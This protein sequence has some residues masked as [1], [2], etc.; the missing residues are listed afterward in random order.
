MKPAFLKDVSTTALRQAARTFRPVISRQKRGIRVAIFF[1]FV[2]TGLKL[3]QPWPLKFVLDR[4]IR[5]GTPG[6]WGLSP[7]MTVGAAAVIT[8][9]LALLQGGLSL[10]LTKRAAEVGRDLAVGIRR[11]VFEH[12]HR[13]ELPFHTSGRTGE[14]LM[15]LTGDVD[16]VRDGLFTQWLRALGAV[17]TFV[18]MVGIMFWLD[19]LLAAVAFI[20]LPVVLIVLPRASRRLRQAT[21][22]QRKRQGSAAAMAAES[23]R[24]IRV[25]KAYTAEDRTTEDFSK[26]SRAGETAGVRAARISAEMERNTDILTGVGLALVLLFGAQ[27]VVSHAITIG[28]LVVFLAYARS[29]YR[30]IG[31]VSDTAV[32]MG[33][34]SAAAERMLQVLQ[35][36]PEDPSE[37]RSAPQFSGEVAFDRVSYAY[38]EGAQALRDVS[39][40][41]PPGSLAMLVGPNG[42]GKS[43]IL[44]I[45]LRLIRPDEG[46][47][48]IDGDPIAEFKVNSYRS[49]FA[50]VPQAIQLFSG[51]L[52]ENIQ[53]GRLDASDEEI[54]EAA[55][56]ALLDDVVDRLPGG[57]EAAL[58]EGGETLSGGEARRLM[59]A[60]AAIRDARVLILDEPLTGLDPDATGT[61]AAAL[62]QI[63]AGRTTI[64][65]SHEAVSEFSPDV[66][67]HLNAGRV[68]DVTHPHVDEAVPV[69]PREDIAAR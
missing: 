36:T 20:P 6:P 44:S 51:T 5:Q 9:V 61:V 27:R 31:N 23:L 53:Y 65:V 18:I 26:E 63:A 62:R 25:V 3:L 64:V 41:L 50:Y 67:V 54:E 2:T 55:R 29:F 59:L 39:F 16:I 38:P 68:V 43:T 12:L 17:M 45:L 48:R 19:P 33:R 32:R 69:S 47:V 13:L 40:T 58:G 52:K 42:S 66:L 46:E 22:R 1:T 15:R 60:R 57:F 34:V 7:Q 30:P 49:R 10:L 37:G 24:H 56:K 21:R 4:V 28:D 35:M 11:Q 8:I 14:L